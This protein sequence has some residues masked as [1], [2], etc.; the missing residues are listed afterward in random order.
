MQEKIV[1][2]PRKDRRGVDSLLCLGKK[3]TG[4]KSERKKKLKM[5]L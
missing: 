4:E 5:T 3:I 1:M 2:W